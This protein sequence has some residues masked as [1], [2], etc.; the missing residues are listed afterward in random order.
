MRRY[1]SIGALMV[2]V[3][4]SPKIVDIVVHNGPC[5]IVPEGV[6]FQFERPIYRKRSTL[7]I[8]TT[9]EIDWK[10]EPPWK[11]I[12]LPDGRHVAVDAKLEAEDGTIFKSTSIASAGDLVLRFASP[13]PRDL[14]IKAVTLRADVPLRGR[15]VR[16][17]EFNAL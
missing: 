6:R 15:N 7:S 1:L 3:G 4:C 16:W 13:P 9:L 2:L 17:Y 14:A 12:R 11:T 5:T 8:R 10:P